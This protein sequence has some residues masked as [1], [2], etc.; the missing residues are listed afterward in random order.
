MMA[1]D[2]GGDD[3]VAAA[4]FELPTAQSTAAAPCAGQEAIGVGFDGTGKGL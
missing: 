1:G 2:T 4:A 3:V